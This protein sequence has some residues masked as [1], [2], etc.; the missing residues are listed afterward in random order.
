MHLQ[1]MQLLSS[2]SASAAAAAAAVNFQLK[3]DDGLHNL[4]ACAQARLR[5]KVVL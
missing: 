3:K 2:S 4:S 5:L 1:L